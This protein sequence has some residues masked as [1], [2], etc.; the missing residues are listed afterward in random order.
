[1][2]LGPQQPSQPLEL[3]GGQHSTDFYVEGLAFADANFPGLISLTVSLLDAS[4]PVGQ[5]GGGGWGLGFQAVALLGGWGVVPSPAGEGRQGLGPGGCNRLSPAPLPA[6]APQGPGVPRQCGVPCG[7]LDHDPQH[8]ACKGGVCV[9]VRGPECYGAG[10]RHT[11]R[12]PEPG[13]PGTCCADGKASWDLHCDSRGL[14]RVG[15]R[16]KSGEIT[17][18]AFA[19]AVL[20]RCGLKAAL[21]PPALGLQ[22]LLGLQ[23]ENP[24]EARLPEFLRV[25]PLELLH[26]KPLGTHMKCTFLA[27]F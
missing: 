20:P 15:D 25:W 9:Q 2:I 5:D 7:A 8:S 24:L 11:G 21:A 13:P 14:W 10:H 1:M 3:P 27:S 16:S 6:G 26:R 22:N 12:S 18:A 19:M 23:D 17:A 4:K